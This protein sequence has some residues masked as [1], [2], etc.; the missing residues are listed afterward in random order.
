MSVNVS[1]KDAKTSSI[2]LKNSFLYCLCFGH[3][4]T[5]IFLLC[6]MLFSLILIFNGKKSLH[7]KF[8]RHMKNLRNVCN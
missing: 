8:G 1:F 5:H 4:V 2:Y 6:F 3:K 7:T